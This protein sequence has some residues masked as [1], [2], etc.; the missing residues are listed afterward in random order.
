MAAARVAA[1]MAAAARAE[2]ARVAAAREMAVSEAA[3]VEPVELTEVAMV[4][5]RAVTAAIEAPW[6]RTTEAAKANE[7]AYHPTAIESGT[8]MEELP[9]SALCTRLCRHPSILC[10][11]CRPC[12]N[13]SR[14]CTDD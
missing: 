10:S 5:A 9:E 13:L 7:P 4:E 1:A 8:N 11:S 2:A 14:I 12:T 3:T 6:A